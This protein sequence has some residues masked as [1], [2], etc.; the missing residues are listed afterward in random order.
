M[1][2]P[3]PILNA[4]PE[5]P[6]WSGPRFKGIPGTA[7][8]AP[9]GWVMVSDSYAGQ[10]AE[11]LRVMDAVPGAVIAALPDAAPAVAEAYGAVLALLASM[12]RF[13]VGAKEVRCP[14]GRKVVLDASRPLETLGALVQEDLCILERQGDE[15]VLTAALLCFPAF[16]TLSEKIG[17]PMTVIHAPVA[18]YTA[19]AARRV[20]RLM[21]GVRPGRPILRHNGAYWHDATLFAP[22]TE[23]AHHAP[24]QPE[25]GRDFYRSE[26][27]CL[28]RLPQTGAVLFTIHTR[29]WRV[30]DLPVPP[31]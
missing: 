27:Q 8:V 12:A 25:R 4:P 1:R 5:D 2:A 19:D 18:S 22:M 15:Y 11:R 14:D 30:A 21:E 10:M 13:E 26:R 6:P 20:G 17:R 23:A 28:V 29:V 31:E 7:P 24:G 9:D 3:A 16:W